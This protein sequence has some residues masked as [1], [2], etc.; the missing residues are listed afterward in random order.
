M[1]DTLESISENLLL[2]RP[3]T[4]LTL[5]RGS[6]A[7]DGRRASYLEVPILCMLI[8]EGPKPISVLGKR[9]YISKPNMT[10]MIDRMITE[11]HIKR[12]PGGADRRVTMIGITENGKKYMKEHKKTVKENI[13]RNLSNLGTEDL[14]RLCTSLEDM[15]I[16]V[17]KISVEE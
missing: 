16:I 3:I 17:S 1:K 13:K 11:G 10:G 15:R 2:F 6:G 9:L 5:M 8:R 7:K 12:L 4:Y 14:E